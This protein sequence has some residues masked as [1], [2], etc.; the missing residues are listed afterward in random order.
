MIRKFSAI[1]ILIASLSLSSCGINLFSKSED[2][3]LGQQMQA[4]IAK[5]PAHYPPLNNPSVTSYVQGIVNTIVSSSNVK[6]KDFHYVVT[7]IRDDNTINAFAIP[8]GPIYV[9]T[10]LLK[11]IDNEATLAG[12]LAHEITHVDHRHSTQQLTKQYGLEIVANV[13]IGATTTEGSTVREMAGYI[14]GIGG[15]LGMLRF[16]RD[17]E[18]EADENSFIDLN[19]LPGKP[20]YPAAIKY[21]MLKTMNA[22]PK[23]ALA[24]N[25]STHPP[26]KERLDNVNKQAAAA[27]L[28][29]PTESQIHAS[30]FMRMRAMLP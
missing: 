18:R 22:D 2:V 12:I 21:F 6:N 28:S 8:G 11:F 30:E 1:L 20:W 13:A 9:Y 4:E 3:K 27:H 14:A 10:G 15:T 29:E 24:K 26:S 16:S 19:T 23:G 5:D 7:I 25:L 17:D